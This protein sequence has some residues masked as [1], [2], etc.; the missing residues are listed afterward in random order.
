[1]RRTRRARNLEG[2]KLKHITGIGRSEGK[3]K[4]TSKKTNDEVS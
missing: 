4:R 2:S 3:K 1:M